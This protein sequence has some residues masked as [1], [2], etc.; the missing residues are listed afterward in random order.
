MAGMGDGMVVWQ[1]EMA[2]Y[3]LFIVHTNN[4]DDTDDD[5]DDDTFY[6]FIVL[7]HISL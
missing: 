5:D 6:F 2:T 4:T 3:V 7:I 1:T